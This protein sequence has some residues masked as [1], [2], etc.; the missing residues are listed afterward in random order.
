MLNAIAL[1]RAMQAEAPQLIYRDA[2]RTVITQVVA[3]AVFAF[4][5]EELL[6][7]VG[8]ARAVGKH[9]DVWAKY[10]DLRLEQALGYFREVFEMSPAHG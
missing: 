3:N 1:Y 5:R 4:V 10:G 6:A 2:L 9:D 7:Y 8:T